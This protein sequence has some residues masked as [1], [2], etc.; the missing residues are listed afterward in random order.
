MRYPLLAVGALTLLAVFVTV[1]ADP[2]KLGPEWT[3][4]KEMRE[5]KKSLPIK[6][7]RSGGGNTQGYHL[8]LQHDKVVVY[9]TDENIATGVY[10]NGKMQFDIRKDPKG[11]PSQIS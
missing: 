2:P 1:A 11:G 4:D 8:D 9:E 6:V 7:T 5:Y 3:Y 10:I